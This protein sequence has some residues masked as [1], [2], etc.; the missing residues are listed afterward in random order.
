MYGGLDLAETTDLVRVR[1]DCVQ[2]EHGCWHVKAWFW[3]PERTLS[4]HAKRDRAPYDKWVEDG[5]I[6]A[7][8]GVAV[9]YEYVARRIA[10]ICEPMSVAK[11]AYDRFRFKTLEAQFAK[12]DVVLPFEPFGQGYVSMAPAMDAT[13]IVFLNEKVRHGSNAVMTMCAANAVVIRDPAG[14]R[15]L[16]KWKSTGR[17]DGLVALVMAMGVAMLE[18]ESGGSPDDFLANV[19][20]A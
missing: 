14:N 4:D 8:P 1:T 17:I 6:E 12:I 9:D 2:D 13:E 5:L 3:K 11:I 20:V 18:D 7:V 10:E 15:K 19:V 16:D